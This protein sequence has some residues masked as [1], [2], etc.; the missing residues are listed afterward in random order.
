MMAAM[1]FFV[2]FFA[3][4]ASRNYYLQLGHC[5][6]TYSKYEFITVDF[7]FVRYN[8][9]LAIVCFCLCVAFNKAHKYLFNKCVNKLFF[10][11]I[12]AEGNINRGKSNTINF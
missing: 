1:V 11:Q 4:I 3:Y 10:M 5:S 6:G 2:T 12:R 8:V 7:D 9:F